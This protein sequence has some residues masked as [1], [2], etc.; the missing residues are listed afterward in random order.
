M[1]GR[2]VD[3]PELRGRSRVFAD[4]GE[5]GRVLGRMLAAYAGSSA[6]VCALPAGGVP[7]ALPVADALGLELR[8]AAVSKITLP[9]NTEA[10]YG[11]VAFDGTVRVNDDIVASVGLTPSQVEAG[12]ARTLAK[13]RRRME[14]LEAGGA[15]VA[16]AGADI[17]LVD[18][19]LASGLTMTTAVEALGKAGAA[20]LAAAVPTGHENAVRR[21]AE[22]VDTVYCPNIR[23]RY[24]FAV[25]EAYRSWSDVPEAEACDMLAGRGRAG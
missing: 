22:R 16:P 13:V 25:A 17:I 7:V 2:I 15:A 23:S 6:V 19:G 9:W 8:A 21:L 1:K 4:R 5:G 20:R 18:D 12:T 11:A 14:Q 10:G 3:L 24:P